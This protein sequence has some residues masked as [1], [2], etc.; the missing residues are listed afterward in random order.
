MKILVIHQVP[1]RKIDYG[2]AIDHGVHEVTYAGPADS[3][4]DIPGDLPC[5]RLETPAGEDLAEAVIARTSP[6]DGYEHVL[7]LSEFGGFVAHRVREHLGLPGPSLEQVERVRDKVAMKEALRGSAI[8]VPLFVSRPPACGPLPWTG[9]TVIKPRQGASSEGVRV[10][11]TARQALCAYRKLE[12][13]RDHQLEEYIE[14]HVLH[15]DG[16]VR[17]GRL[18]TL[19]T[20]RYVGKPVDYVAGRPLGSHQIPPDP[21]HHGFAQRVVDAL[22]ITTGSV[23]LEYFETP[24][25]DLVF[26]EIGNRVGGAG[27]V[28]AHHRHTGSHLPSLEIAAYLGLA[29]RPPAQPSGRYHGW[30]VF[31]GHHLPAGGH[32]RI[33]VPPRLRDHPCVDRMHVLPP[34]RPLPA[35]VTYQEWQAPVFVEASH[36]DPESLRDFLADCARSITVE[37]GTAP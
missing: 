9:K 13:R 21:R 22:G 26:L 36:T 29:P 5:G 31:P 19:V 28:T 15:T 1:Y 30:L 7:S 8:R 14:G 32:H 24:D 10:Y 37:R 33:T 34:T 20:S 11:E 16:V 23:H 18:I 25:D 27:V 3:L 35:T 2:R 6:A 4:A 17:D 12:N